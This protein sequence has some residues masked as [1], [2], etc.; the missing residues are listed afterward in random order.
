MAI[1]NFTSEDGRFGL[2]IEHREL[3][4][5]R[6]HCSTWKSTETGGILVGHYNGQRNSAIVTKASLAPKDSQRGRTWFVRGVSQL[7][8]WLKELWAGRGEYYL[9][10][11]HYHPGGSCQPSGTDCHQMSEIADDVKYGCPE[12]LMIIVAQPRAGKWE[13]GAYVFPTKGQMLALH[14]ASK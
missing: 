13:I 11:W 12:P 7:Q 1:I 3:D 4:R 2:Q 6:D 10:E 8:K 5:M 14:E 9:G